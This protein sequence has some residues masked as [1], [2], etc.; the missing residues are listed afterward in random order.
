MYIWEPASESQ[1]IY[2][3][4]PSTTPGLFYDVLHVEQSAEGWHGF[5]LV[6]NPPSY[7]EE[8]DTFDKGGFVILDEEL[9]N[10]QDQAV[11]WCEQRDTA[12]HNRE[13]PND[14]YTE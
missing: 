3:Y 12:R 13:K 7:E 4:N 10:T 6:F 8:S 14:E 5:L 1:W 11:L 9:F 2:G